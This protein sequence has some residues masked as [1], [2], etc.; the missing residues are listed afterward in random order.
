MINVVIVEDNA[1]E[2]KVLSKHLSDYAERE[3]VQFNVS[4]Y[5]DAVMFL[6]EYKADADIIFMDINMPELTGMEAAGELR[7]IDEKVVLIFVTDM[8][9]YAVQGYSVN[10]LDFILKPITYYVVSTSLNRALKII[11]SRDDQE[12]LLKSN[13]IVKRLPLSEI[14]YIE[15]NRHRLVYHTTSGDFEGWGTMDNLEKTLPPDRFSRCNI[16]YIV[17]LKHVDTV[18][19]SD[20]I[21]G[22]D[23]LKISR[24]RKKAFLASIA[25]Y[26]GRSVGGGGH[27]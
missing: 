4:V 27:V 15:V 19:G 1:A 25:A 11:S 3:G 10:A 13:G 2:A 21:V 16:A 5:S 9:Q 26:L 6:K 12:L 23:R 14:M 20:V 22:K 7:K 18:D 8:A 17:G 24:T